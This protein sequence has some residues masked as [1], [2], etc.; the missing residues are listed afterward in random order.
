MC[1]F[2]KSLDMKVRRLVLIGWC[3]LTKIDD[4][5]KMVV[6]TSSEWTSEEE[7]STTS[8]WMALNAIIYGV[9]FRQFSLI[10]FS[11]SAKEA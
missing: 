9:D 10:S 2:I 5:G 3:P 1:I 4:D 7:K 8:N 11:K 6:K